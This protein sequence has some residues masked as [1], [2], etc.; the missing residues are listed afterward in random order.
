MN[1]RV[2][3]GIADTPAVISGHAAQ[4]PTLLTAARDAGA[5]FAII[6]TAP[7]SG[8]VTLIVLGRKGPQRKEY[9]PHEQAE[10]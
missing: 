10:H 6:D 7:H 4:L 5:K 9:T 3:L 1:P 2:R 8:I